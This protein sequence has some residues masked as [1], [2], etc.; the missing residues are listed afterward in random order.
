MNVFQCMWVV[1]SVLAVDSSAQTFGAVVSTPVPGLSLAA[2]GL[3][4]ADGDGRLDVIAAPRGNSVVHTIAGDGAGGFGAVT[5]SSPAYGMPTDAAAFF[6]A[7]GDGRVDVVVSG[8]LTQ[9]GVRLLSGD[10]SGGFVQ[11]PPIAGLP[12]TF[13]GMRVDGD[14]HPDLVGIGSFSGVLSVAFGAPGGGFRPAVAVAVGVPMPL[15]PRD[16]VSGDVDG[17]G[18]ED[19]LVGLPP[20]VMLSDGAGGFP[21]GS[22][23][24]VQAQLP[25]ALGDFDGD[26]RLDLLAQDNVGIVRLF[27]NDGFG[28]FEAPTFALSGQSSFLRVVRTADVDGDGNTDALIATGSSIQVWLGDGAGGFASSERPTS[29]CSARTHRPTPPDCC[30]PAPRSTVAGP[31]SA[32]T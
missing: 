15:F 20:V 31:R 30:W 1:G 29:G 17:D 7:T 9:S 25:R 3:L 6:D 11:G 10:G 32:S 2:I 23:L 24:P 5:T 16:F 12:L 4:D 14:E 22:Q 21:G 28:G 27:R 26:G 19:L 13:H 8:A 18:D